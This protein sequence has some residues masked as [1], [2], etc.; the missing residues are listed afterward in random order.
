M[1]V[2][3]E[4]FCREDEDDARSKTFAELM[5]DEPLSENFAKALAGEKTA[6][7]IVAQ[8]DEGDEEEVEVILAP[9]RD[10]RK[11]CGVVGSVI[12]A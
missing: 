10:G 8:A 7:S 12:K 3:V 1:A 9:N 11:I 4:M 6:V 2:L 5:S